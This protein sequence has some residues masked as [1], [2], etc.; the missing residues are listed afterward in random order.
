MPTCLHQCPLSNEHSHDPWGNCWA[1]SQPTNLFYVLSKNTGTLN[2]HNLDILA[3]TIELM[4][5]SARIFPAQETNVHWHE[6]TSYHLC[7]QSQH[8]TTQFQLAMSTS[9]EKHL[10]GL[11]QVELSPW[12]STNGLARLFQ[13][14]WTPS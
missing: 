7:T 8:A 10:T 2:L 12:P 13:V 3:I 11:N 1:L 5:L 6:E 4:L 14:A 9:T